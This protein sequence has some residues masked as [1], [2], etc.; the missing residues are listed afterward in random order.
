MEAVVRDGQK[1]DRVEGREKAE[2]SRVLLPGPTRGNVLDA[3]N[4]KLIILWIV[5]E[6]AVV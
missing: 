2:E 5:V 4:V 1:G 6:T 3:V